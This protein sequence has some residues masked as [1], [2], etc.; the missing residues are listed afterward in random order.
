M[1]DLKVLKRFSKITFYLF[2]KVATCNHTKTRVCN[3]TRQKQSAFSFHP[4]TKKTRN[5]RKQQTPRE[6][7]RENFLVTPPSPRKRWKKLTPING[8]S[9]LGLSRDEFAAKLAQTSR[10]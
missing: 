4:T 3:P 10:V 9:N 5:T 6:K 1:H 8:S 7:R 2:A